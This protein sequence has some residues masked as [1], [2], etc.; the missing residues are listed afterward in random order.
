MIESQAQET[1]EKKQSDEIFTP[2]L[3][4]PL[5]VST[6]KVQ[7]HKPS[8]DPFICLFENVFYDDFSDQVVQFMEKFQ[9]PTF[10]TSWRR[11][12]P[13]FIPSLDYPASQLI[14]EKVY[15]ILTHTFKMYAEEIK[16]PMPT[17]SHLEK[18]SLLKYNP[19]SNDFFA[20]HSDNFHAESSA[21]QIS[22]I[23]YI[24]DVEKGG[25][26][27]FPYHQAITQDQLVIRCK[28][29]SVLFFPSGFTYV[30]QANPP[31]SNP[32]VVIVSWFCYDM[33]GSQTGYASYLL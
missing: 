29:G 2:S 4:P 28:K 10:E 33:K 1:K 8:L 23:L 11:C 20:L 9:T 3:M 7:I 27:V 21:R 12:C 24:N 6:K 14:Y 19:A 17:V 30:H 15:Q 25:E 22:A 5:S 18:P 26:T 31:I 16:I 13:L 32:K